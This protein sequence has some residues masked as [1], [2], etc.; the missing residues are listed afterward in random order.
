MTSARHPIK[1]QRIANGFTLVE[2]LVALF[3]FGLLSVAGVSLLRVSADGQSA[4]NARL[5]DVAV[6]NRISG[7]LIADLAQAVARPVRDRDGVRRAAFTASE[8]G[9]LFAFTR[10]GWSNFDDSPRPEIQRVSYVFADGE[11]RRVGGQQVDGGSPQDAATMMTGLSTVAVRF[12]DDVGNWRDDWSAADADVL[13]RAVELVLVTGQ[14]TRFMLLLPT[15][16]RTRKPVVR[17]AVSE[18]GAP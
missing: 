2:M 7:A 6:I 9:S 8:D 12:R 3:I 11:L 14:G 5:D 10:A 4:I 18:D 15:G 1:G 13:P 16:S 17:E